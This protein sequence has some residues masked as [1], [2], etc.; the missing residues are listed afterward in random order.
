MKR[1]AF[2]RHVGDG[3]SAKKMA[4]E[5]KMSV[6]AVHKTKRRLI[7]MVCREYETLAHRPPRTAVG[8]APGKD[9]VPERKGAS[10]RI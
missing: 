5:L 9:K 3:L 7:A 6:G 1:R 4:K 8:R 2:Q 10:D